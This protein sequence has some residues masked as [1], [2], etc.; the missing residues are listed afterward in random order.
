MA[1]EVRPTRDL[2][3]FRRAVGAIGHYFGGWP[4]DDEAAQRF[5]ANLPFDRMHAALDGDRIVGGAGAFPFELTVP[6]GTVGCA[7]VT[8]V[9]V[10]PTHRRRGILTAMM[11]AQ[12]EDVRDRG[13]PIAALW[14][15]EEAIYRR[16]GYG[17]AS[18]AGEIAIPSGYATL[19]QPPDERA[20]LRL[21]PLDQA[22]DVIAPIY[23]RVRVGRPGMF[24]RTD[25]WWE[26]RNL[27]DPPE[28]RQGG[29][30]KNCVVLELDGEPVGY[31]LYRIHTKFEAGAAAGHVDAIEALADGPV[32]LR[33]L[34]RVLL[35]MDWKA[36]LKGYL[37]PIDHPLLHQLAYPRRMQMRIGDG[38]WVRLVDVPAALAA[39]S[40]GGDGAVVL[41]VRD[42]FLPEN[43]G[44]WRLEGGTVE[45]T[46]E[47]PDLELDVGELGSVYL[48]GFTFG[49]LRRAGL[50]HEA[51]EG[52]TARADAVF[53]TEG[54][55]PWCPEIF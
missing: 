1:F 15:S 42:G 4:A 47:E 53:F 16:F 26:T 33:E 12:L 40:Y 30:E 23:D 31:A 39:R 44:R 24:A 34:W 13:E 11:R 55:K 48:G 51:R 37:L 20:S 52:G 50:V 46:D 8:V 27:P 7:G 6:G 5:A 21:V 43:E 17:L 49:E 35:E 14:A 29:G 3:E 36:T 28:R 18:L 25:S 45:R 38:L 41:D 32:A 22:R 9:G 54:P 19:R 2:E 10:L